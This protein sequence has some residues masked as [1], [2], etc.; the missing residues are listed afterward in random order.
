M[1]GRRKQSWESEGGRE[2]SGWDRGRGGEKRNL[3]R[4]WRREQE[5]HPEGQQNEWKYA[6]LGCSRVGMGGSLGD[7]EE[8]EWD[9][10]LWK[11]RQEGVLMTAL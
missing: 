1:G 6:T 5:T 10:K 9:K 2:G 3:V 7:S 8:E 11:G 4:F